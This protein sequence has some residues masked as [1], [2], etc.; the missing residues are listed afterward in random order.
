MDVYGYGTYGYGMLWL[1]Y[2]IDIC[3]YSLGYGYGYGNPPV[4]WNPKNR[5]G[6]TLVPIK[7]NG[8]IMVYPW[9][10]LIG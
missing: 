4:D 6:M 7:S 9:V 10:Y 8:L 3:W 2:P 5:S 1:W